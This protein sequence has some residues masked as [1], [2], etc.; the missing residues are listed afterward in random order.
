MPIIKE[1]S[2]DG[3]Q[4]WFI[5]N[6]VDYVG[7]VL[8]NGNVFVEKA[9]FANGPSLL[10]QKNLFICLHLSTSIMYMQVVDDKLSQLFVGVD[11]YMVSMTL[12]A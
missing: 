6:G 4:L 2:E 8:T 5:S 7:N 3:K 12:L 10:G 1:V 9:K 11:S